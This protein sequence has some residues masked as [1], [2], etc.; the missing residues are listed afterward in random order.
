MAEKAGTVHQNSDDGDA[1]HRLSEDLEA[2]KL[3]KSILWKLDTRVLPLLA[4]L[5][6]FNFLDRSNV[7]NAKI[8]GLQNDLAITNSQYATSLAVFFVFYVVS[9]LPSNLIVKRA[10]P[11]IW[12]P[13]LGFLWGTTIMCTGFVKTYGQLLALR[14]LLGTFEGGLYPGCLLYFSNMYTR[15]ELALRVGL[16]YSMASLSGAFGGLLARGLSAI[17]PTSGVGSGWRWIMI[18]EGIITIVVA[19]T[20]FIF[21]PNS[22]DSD[23]FTPAERQHAIARLRKSY[24][25]SNLGRKA[26]P[27]RFQWSEVRRGIFSPQTLLT[28]TAYFAICCALFSFSLFLPSIVAAMG[29]TS[30]QAQL[31]TVP[32]YA[33][34]SVLSACYAILSDRIHLRGTL[35]LFSLPLGII[36]Y[37]IIARTDNSASVKYG[38]TFLMATGIYMSVPTILVWLLNN[39]AGHYKRAAAGAVQV[40]LAN[41]GGIVAAFLYPDV[42]SPSYS[43]SH[44][45]IM[46]CLCYAWLAVLINVLYCRK[47]NKDKENGKYDRY[48]GYGDDREPSFKLV[49]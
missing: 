2:K 49:I 25:S 8:L 41:C 38:M 47:V 32:P 31:L 24:D 7:G 28:G 22:V 44:H 43:K 30:N 12:L 40:G 16:F 5:Y 48:I 20:V 13:T 29:Y 42:E 14:V 26:E 1:Q 10:T 27:E 18:I 6:L 45:I 23:F 21:L 39:S 33:V 11:K 19:I 17:S 36:G 46:G 3:T 34:A 9:E 37:G 4:V 35:S 15:E